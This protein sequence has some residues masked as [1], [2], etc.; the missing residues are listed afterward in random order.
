MNLRTWWNKRSFLVAPLPLWLL[1]LAPVTA[2]TLIRKRI[3]GTR[4]CLIHSRCT[5]ECWCYTLYLSKSRTESPA[6]LPVSISIFFHMTV[7][8]CCSR[9]AHRRD[10]TI[11]CFF[12]FFPPEAAAARSANWHPVLYPGVHAETRLVPAEHV[13]GPVPAAAPQKGPD[14]AQVHRRWHVRPLLV[15]TLVFIT[16]RIITQ[17][18]TCTFIYE[19]LWPSFINLA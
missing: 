14:A 2:M 16:E 10:H 12:F 11:I 18:T 1:G 13:P 4:T 7:A 19:S 3:N 17:H 8:V 5:F 9:L 6:P 15:D